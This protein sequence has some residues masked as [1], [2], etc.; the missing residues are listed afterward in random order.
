ML[1]GE[2]LNLSAVTISSREQ[3]AQNEKIK[4]HYKQFEVVCETPLITDNCTALF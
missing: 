2:G 4:E 3:A 1:L